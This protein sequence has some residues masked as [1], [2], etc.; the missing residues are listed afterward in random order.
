MSLRNGTLLAAAHGGDGGGGTAYCAAAGGAGARLRGEPE[1]VGGYINFA[2]VSSD[3]DAR[4]GDRSTASCPGEPLV[5]TLS[6]DSVEFTWNHGSHHTQP[7]ELYAQ[8]YTVQLSRGIL[9]EEGDTHKCSEEYKLHEHIPRSIDSTRHASTWIRNLEPS[10]PHCIHIEAFSVEGLSLGVQVLPFTTEAAPVNRWAPVIVKQASTISEKAHAA[11]EMNPN[12][13]EDLPSASWCEYSPGRPT[14]RRGHSMTIVND[15]VYIFG[16]ATLKCVCEKQHS[17][18][19]SVSPSPD[20]AKPQCSSKNV[21]SDELWHYD[22]K[23]ESFSQ[24]SG[25]VGQPWPRGREQHSA[26]ALPDGNIIVIGGLSTSS[27]DL[28]IHSSS[29]KLLLADVWRMKDPHHILSRVFRGSAHSVHD[30]ETV[31]PLELTTGHVTSHQLAVD[32]QNEDEEL[33]QRCIVGIQVRVVLETSCLKDIEYIKLTG[34]GTKDVPKHNAPQSRDYEAKVSSSAIIPLYLFSFSLCSKSCVSFA[35]PR[36]LFV[37]SM[38]S[39]EHVCRSSSLDLLFSDDATESI[40]R[41][42]SIPTS[43]MFR[44]ATSLSGVFDGLPIRGKWKISIAQSH[45]MHPEIYTARLVDWEIKLMSKPC[46]ARVKWEKLGPAVSSSSSFSPRRLHTAVAVDDNIFIA[47]GFSER[48][49]DDLWRFN[50]DS[51]TLIELNNGATNTWP[52]NGQAAFL[53][54]YGLLAYGGLGKHGPLQQGKDL[55]L[56]DLFQ[57]DWVSVP[58]VPQ[59][60]IDDNRHFK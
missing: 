9:S 3:D 14:G 40:L 7:K 36:Q 52:L 50:Y 20:D 54:Q 33:N 2:Y 10:T 15:Q 21:Y 4:D 49:L 32:F 17:D 60:N 22:P 42:A 45:P 28:E 24:L 34:P 26:T 55:W 51:N 46:V 38:D 35:C 19:D 23:T 13:D 56:L 39:R 27:K 11:P 43:G 18:D 44:S 5:V 58:I 16:G 59:K 31:L 25:E 47:G 12:N 8:K 29:E 57:D 53:G 48:R 1:G 6:H 37:S 41:F 30:G